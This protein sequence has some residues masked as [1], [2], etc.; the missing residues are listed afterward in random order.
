[1]LCMNWLYMYLHVGPAQVD[2]VPPLGLEAAV[3]LR[4][5]V[6]E[7]LA[8][9]DVVVVL[10]GDGLRHCARVPGRV[11]C[12]RPVQ[13]TNTHSTYSGPNIAIE[14]TDSAIFLSTICC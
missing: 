10:D 13:A 8:V 2:V 3:L 4:L 7:L 5:G 6:H 11:Q 1:M 12:V 9:G 14:K